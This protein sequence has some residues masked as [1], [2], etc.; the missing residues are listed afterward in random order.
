MR[1]EKQKGK[2]VTN[3]DY[4]M[5]V[6]RATL[7]LQRNVDRK[8]RQVFELNICEMDKGKFYSPVVLLVYASR[9]VLLAN[10]K[11]RLNFKNIK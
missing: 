4:V 11:E 1:R 5:S 8:L 3:P 6:L 2:D 10:K 7:F 9:E